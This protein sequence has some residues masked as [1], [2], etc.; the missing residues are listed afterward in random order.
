M[1]IID[2]ILQKNTYKTHKNFHSKSLSLCLESSRK[3]RFTAS[4]KLKW[5]LQY[6]ILRN[7]NLL[8][9]VYLREKKNI[10]CVSS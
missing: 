2:H 8:K 9:I 3:L 5:Q 4:E 6:K 7:R 1:W 10:A